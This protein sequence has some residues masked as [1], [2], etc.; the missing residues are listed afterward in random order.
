[1]PQPI[2][3]P[4]SL[5]GLEIVGPMNPR[6]AEILSPAA[7]R[8]LAGLFST[9][10]PRREALLARRVERQREIDA[11]KLP[12][13]LPETAAIRRAEWR[14]RPPPADLVDRRAEIT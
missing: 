2:M 6:Y 1:M 12:D 3:K 11:G 8:F 4:L 5:E 14:V 10:G 9:F 13:F 7:C